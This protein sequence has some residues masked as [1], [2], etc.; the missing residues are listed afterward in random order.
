MPS[1]L[2]GGSFTN[3]QEIQDSYRGPIRP[4]DER[5]GNGALPPGMQGSANLAYTR[6]PQADE[7]SGNQISALLASNNPYV[8]NARRRGTEQAGSRGMLNG[9]IAAGA[10]ERSAI[11]AAAPL[12]L[13]QAGAYTSAASDNQQ[14]LNQIAMQRNEMINNNN[15]RENA[16]IAAG[17]ASRDRLQLQREQLAFEGEQSGLDRSQQNYRD[18]TGYN[19]NIGR[20]SNQAA[21][22]SYYG[23]RDY[24]FRMQTD[25]RAAYATFRRNLAQAAM[26]NPDLWTPEDVEGFSATMEP[27]LQDGDY[28][29]DDYFDSYF[30]GY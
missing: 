19:Y 24:A 13:Q 23:Q 15:E 22:G 12:A 8:A 29:L 18:Y 25:S 10:A 11:D 30:G 27:F 1:A 21:L 14:Y 9:S 20:D 4:Y 17:N 26:D 7:M 28:Y 2:I 3:G 16:R 5:I 6:T